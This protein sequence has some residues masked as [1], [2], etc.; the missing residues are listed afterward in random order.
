VSRFAA[1]AT[2]PELAERCL[3]TLREWSR[4]QSDVGRRATRKANRLADA[5]RLYLQTLATTADGRRHIDS[6]LDDDD[7]GVRAWAAAHALFWNEPKARRVLERLEASDTFPD[8]FN[9]EMTLRQFDA[10]R[11]RP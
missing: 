9:A 2:V 11:L 1:T 4:L 6:F 10:G 7:P 8:N 3:A 5:Q